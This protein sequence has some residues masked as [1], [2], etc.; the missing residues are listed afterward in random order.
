[1]RLLLDT[2]I[3]LWFLAGA[4][5]IPRAARQAIEATENLVLVSAAAIWEI[6][7]KASIGRLD[8]TR[9]DVARLPRLIEMAGFRELPVLARH[10]VGVHV[11]PL[12]HRDPFDRLLVAQ[13]RAEELTL[14]TVD[15]AIR[16]YGVSVL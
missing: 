15:P 9:S 7:V 2:Q 5:R 14:V 12:H 16:R 3:F 11:L 4:S 6:A 8:I 10:A 1:M 13:A